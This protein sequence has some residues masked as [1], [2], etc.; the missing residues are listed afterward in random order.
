L[1][2]AESGTL[3]LP[4][5]NERTGTLNAVL[6]AVCEKSS[7]PM[8]GPQLYQS[9]VKLKPS[10]LVGFAVSC[11]MSVALTTV[12]VSGKVGPVLKRIRPFCTAKDGPA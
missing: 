6:S 2:A 5:A 3:L 9:P 7:A 12:A 10:A 11:A 4:L 1:L 8:V